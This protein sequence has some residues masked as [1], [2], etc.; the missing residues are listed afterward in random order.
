MIVWECLLSS[1]LVSRH[2][3]HV[4][5]YDHFSTPANGILTML[6]TNCCK[7]PFTAK[8]QPSSLLDNFSQISVIPGGL[9]LGFTSWFVIETDLSCYFCF[10]IW[11]DNGGSAFPKSS[12]TFYLTCFFGWNCGLSSVQSRPVHINQQVP[13]ISRP[14][15]PLKLKWLNP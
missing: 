15:Q 8:L 4:R 12:C 13:G 9:L 6:L 11:Q 1:I 14:A 3:S 2:D 5:I 7:I 10:L